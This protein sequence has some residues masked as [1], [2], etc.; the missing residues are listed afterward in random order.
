MQSCPDDNVLQGFLN[1]SGTADD[2]QFVHDHIDACPRC[3][4]R[5]EQLAGKPR[6]QQLVP[7]GHALVDTD[8]RH[9]TDDGRAT[10][11]RAEPL[12][13]EGY[14]IVDELGR[15]GMG[16]VYRAVHHRLKRDVALKV[17]TA[18]A[19]VNPE[20]WLR[21]QT[22][23][24]AIARLQHVGIVQVFDSGESHR[25]PFVA[26]EIA[27]DGS[28]ADQ[29]SGIPVEP[30][31]SA[32][33][34]RQLALAVAHAHDRDVLHRDIKPTNILNADG[35]F[36][37]ADFGLAKITD[38]TISLTETEDI[39]G[40]P[41]YMAPEQSAGQRS[42]I[43]RATDIHALGVVLYEMLC[44]TVPYRGSSAVETLRLIVEK[45]PVRPRQ[46]VPSVPR[47]LE[48]ICLKC[49][50]KDVG[51]RY[52]TA[53]ELAD[54]LQ[55]FLDGRPI[56][57]QPA[58]SFSRVVKWARR[59]PLAAT[60]VS[61]VLMIAVALVAVWINFTAE[62]TSLNTELTS[63]NSDLNQTNEQLREQTRLADEKA[64][65][66][67]SVS[68]FLRNDLLSQVSA[69]AQFDWLASIGMSVS[70]Y[71][72]D[73]TVRDVLQRV[74][75][76]LEADT[77]DEH[78]RVK[79]QLYLTVGNSYHSLG[80]YRDAIRLLQR[81]Q[82]ILHEHPQPKDADLLACQRHLAMSLTAEE[83]YQQA[84]TVLTAAHEMAVR[85]FGTDSYEAMV[86]QVDLAGINGLFGDKQQAVTSGTAALEA[87]EAQLGEDHPAVLKAAS[88]MGDL[89]LTLEQ[90]DA[91][92]PL[93]ERVARVAEE[94]F[95]PRHPTTL[96]ARHRLAEACHYNLQTDRSAI[97][98][99]SVWE[100][101]EDV[102]G[103]EHPVTHVYQL[104]AVQ[105]VSHERDLP[106][107][108]TLTEQSHKVLTEFYPVGHPLVW[109]AEKRLAEMYADAHRYEEALAV[110]SRLLQMSRTH[111]GKDS[112]KAFIA[113]LMQAQHLSRTGDHDGA[114]SRLRELE[115][116]RDAVSPSTSR[117]LIEVRRG[118][119]RALHQSGRLDEAL[120][121][122]KQSHQ[123]HRDFF[124]ADSMAAFNA[125]ISVML[126][127]Q[128]KQDHEEMITITRQILD[129]TRDT[130]PE[131]ER[132]LL[133][134]RQALAHA[135]SSLLRWDEAEVTLV[136]TS[137]IYLRKWPEDPNAHFYLAMLAACYVRQDRL[138][139]GEQ[140]ALAAWEGLQ[141][142]GP[143]PPTP[144]QT[145]RLQQLCRVLITV[146]EA[147]SETE[148]RQQWQDTLDQLS[149][150][151]ASD[152]K[153]AEPDKPD[154]QTSDNSAE[155]P[156]KARPDSEEGGSGPGDS[157]DTASS[158]HANAHDAIRDTARRVVGNDH[159]T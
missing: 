86:T 18:S 108:V 81:A 100:T 128:A 60:L 56:L 74:E 125:G 24:Q 76:R 129:D 49:L 122:L 72:R 30:A 150:T 10:A 25:T 51:Q 71:K 106:R 98:V 158:S 8:T 96:Q 67:S 140:T 57:A 50:E 155:S 157:P 48:T 133:V 12:T 152:A 16:V 94:R 143:S 146:Y 70:S 120:Q 7:H 19:A 115:Q 61:A 124:G 144:V 45:E 88:L 104:A 40:T 9:A 59:Q 92:L 17:L 63:R 112:R 33:I 93:M 43:G 31:R 111:F 134:V 154:E 34:L 118:I 65:L 147:R 73:P 139:K 95:G 13:I 119:G 28:L 141:K 142:Y 54:D 153:T 99:Q 68:T 36:K 131:E 151:R 101:A 64:F 85:D 41:V 79:G 109:K 159:R 5:L 117:T 44:G 69:E 82:D 58:S 27:S 87:L 15:G 97:L 103:P 102:F 23:A 90:Y 84:R 121:V 116:T 107:A 135:Q 11:E 127:V 2:Q 26:M 105:G 39:I 1:E 83:D 149:G 137:E 123:E 53:E 29:L 38:D 37:L 114:L 91:A 126:V 20:R 138:D 46:H 145:G 4:A 32:G 21:F 14:T 22:E 136:E 35:Q 42:Q 55:R 156:D 47:D 78:P 66:A 75:G 77:F 148:K 6:W 62:V 3:V 89:L 52:G 130:F 110:S 113:A 80:R 132:T